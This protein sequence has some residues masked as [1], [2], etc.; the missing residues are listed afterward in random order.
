MPPNA[1][2][3]A[4]NV[5]ARSMTI[6]RPFI[7]QRAWNGKYVVLSKGPLAADLQKMAGDVAFNSDAD[8]VFTIEV[9]AEE[10]CRFGNFFLETWSNRSRLTPGW[11][12]TLRA[13]LLLYHFL[14][15][16]LL[17]RIPLGKLQDWAFRR[18]RIYDFPERVQAKRDQRNDTWGRCVPIAVVVDELGLGL[19]FRP[20][21]E[22]EGRAAA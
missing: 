6:L 2:D 17:Y 19:P 13:D 22:T 21:A 3:D 1:F 11:M 9:K 14:A 7:E 20:A 5:E 8:T 10:D 4:R 16:D 12:V 18:N 15:E